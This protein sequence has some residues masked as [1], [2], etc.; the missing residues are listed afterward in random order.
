MT[1]TPPCPDED[2]LPPKVPGRVQDEETL[3]R[4]AC[5]R[6]WLVHE[7]GRTT[8]S[9]AAFPKRHL[10]GQKGA[11]VSLMRPATPTDEVLKRAKALN[12]EPKW[13]DDPVL[14]RCKA[15]TVRGVVD[16]DGRREFCVNADVVTDALG[17]LVTHASLLRSCPVPDGKD[18]AEWSA[19]RLQLAQEFDEVRHHSG[20]SVKP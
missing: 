12:R 13:S 7:P 10:Q 2:N 20:T 16:C 4:V 9:I 3:L 5:Q 15:G 19:V 17:E 18:R 11:S 14:G 1:D 6:D 8:L